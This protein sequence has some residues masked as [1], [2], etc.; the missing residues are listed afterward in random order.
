MTHL[1]PPRR[2]HLCHKLGSWHCGGKALGGTTPEHHHAGDHLLS[3][4]PWPGRASAAHGA[5]GHAWSVAVPTHMPHIP[6]ARAPFAHRDARSRSSAVCTAAPALAS[7]P[8]WA[9]SPCSASARPPCLPSPQR[10]CWPAACLLWQWTWPPGCGW[11]VLGRQRQRQVPA[12]PVPA[13]PAPP[14]ARVLR[15]R[16]QTALVARRSVQ[17]T[18]DLFKTRSARGPCD[19]LPA[20]ALPNSC[21]PPAAGNSRASFL[22]VCLSCDRRQVALALHPHSL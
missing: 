15:P 18:H 20:P 7:A 22:C 11:Q 14:R 12:T 21:M 6:H 5:A 10:P 2:V 1:L 13:A 3:F 16:T 9:G 19:P 17:V 8:Y 4:C